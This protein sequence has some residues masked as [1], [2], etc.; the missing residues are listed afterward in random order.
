MTRR[1]R[2][3]VLLLSTPIVTFAVLGGYLGKTFAQEDTYRRLRIFEDVVTLILNNYVEEVNLDDVMRGAMRGLS[4][5]LD[6]DSA[7]LNPEEVQLLER[8]ESQPEGRTGLTLTRQYYLRVVAARDGSPGARAGLRT[9]DYVRGIN[10]QPTRDMS[11][12]TGTRL[13]QG[14]PGSTVSVTVIR[15]NAAEPH[16]IELTRERIVSPDV[17]GRIV[18]PSVGYLRIAV[19]GDEAPDAI[20]A[21]ANR[22]IEA[23]ATHLVIDLRGTAEGALETGVAAARLFVGAGTLAVR[24]RRDEEPE[25]TLAE[26]GD[27]SVSL[28]AVVLINPGTS[29]ASELFASALAANDRADL[30]GTRSLGRVAEQRLVK[31]PDGSGLWL[32]WTHYLTA[33][34]EPLHQQGL[35]PTLV[36]ADPSVA[37]GEAPPET[38]PVLD[39]ALERLGSLPPA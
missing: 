18:T 26:P 39:K 28:P 15:D 33:S 9:G 14:R 17:T 37:F 12:V 25:S 36:V 13:L 11:T 10:G 24:Q 34:G 2:L 20:A 31:L 19:F 21:Q 8:H 6:S 22:L 3:L 4:A 23:G 5:G 30:I 16:V 29:G 1:T 32:T 7:Y 35:E 27:G 38:D